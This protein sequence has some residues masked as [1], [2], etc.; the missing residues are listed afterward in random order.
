MLKLIGKK[1][2][3]AV[4]FIALLRKYFFNSEIRERN[5]LK[6]DFIAFISSGTY[7]KTVEKIFRKYLNKKK[8]EKKKERKELLLSG[9]FFHDSHGS[10]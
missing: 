3:S 1:G 10:Y 9:I 7:T 6:H 2:R 5:S 4:G 8:K